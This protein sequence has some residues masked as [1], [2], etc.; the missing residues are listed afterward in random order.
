MSANGTGETRL[1]SD[2][3]WDDYPSWSP[4]SKQIVFSS[5]RD[6][7]YEIYVMNADGSEQTRLTSNEP[8]IGIRPGVPSGE[9][10]RSKLASLSLQPA[11]PPVLPDRYR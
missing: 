11:I 6:G 1:T 9:R 4:D 8:A 10:R 5:L 7:N 2:L 3:A